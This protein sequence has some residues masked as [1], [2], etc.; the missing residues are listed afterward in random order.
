[1]TCPYNTSHHD[2]RRAYIPLTHGLT[3]PGDHTGSRLECGDYGSSVDSPLASVTVGRGA[4]V[5]TLSDCGV[6]LRTTTSTSASSAITST[7]A[8][9]RRLRRGVLM[10]IPARV[11][12]SSS[13]VCS[14][15]MVSSRLPLRWV[16]SSRYSR[17]RSAAWIAVRSST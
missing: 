1:M 2:L 11:V 13:H 8:R 15:P 12:L 14:I 10:A 6:L 17:L 7:A 3:L 9:T 5:G 4:E 16:I